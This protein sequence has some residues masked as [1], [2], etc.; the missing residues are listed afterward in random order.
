MPKAPR[1]SENIRCI[2]Q[3]FELQVE[4]TASAIA[5]SEG[6]PSSV[7]R[8]LTYLELNTRAN[9]LA[10]YLQ[11]QGV[12]PETVVGIY[13]ERSLELVIAIL[14]VLKAGGAIYLSIR[15]FLPDV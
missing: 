13:L 4:R 10:R 11:K 14:G 9:W 1:N 7:Q 5:V 3:L 15:T 12:G 2:H 6:W 8:S